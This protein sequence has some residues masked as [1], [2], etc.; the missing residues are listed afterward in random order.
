MHTAHLQ[1]LVLN[2]MLKTSWPNTS[3]FDVNLKQDAERYVP[4]RNTGKIA[5]HPAPSWHNRAVCHRFCSSPN[6]TL[7]SRRD[8][9]QRSTHRKQKKNIALQSWPSQ[10]TL[11]FDPLAK[12]CPHCRIYLRELHMLCRNFDLDCPGTTEGHSP[13]CRHRTASC[14]SR[15]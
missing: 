13:H 12:C 9:E 8:W 2:Q 10:W 7:Q 14:S 11:Q 15:L 3:N 5:E 6:D 1:P 4:H